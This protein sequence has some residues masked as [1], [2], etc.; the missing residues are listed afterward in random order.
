MK[1]N[2]EDIEL[3]ELFIDGELNPEETI[4]IENRLKED[5]DFARLFQLRKTLPGIWNKSNQ[6]EQVKKEVIHAFENKENKQLSFFRSRNYALAAVIL[7]FIAS[8]AIYSIFIHGHNA[9][10]SNSDNLVKKEDS[11]VIRNP[12]N[13]AAKARKET[14]STNKEK[15]FCLLEP[16]DSTTYKCTQKIL[17]QWKKNNKIATLYIFLIKTDKLVFKKEIPVGQDSCVL[18]PG[19]L[20]EGEYYWYL[21]D[22]MIKRFFGVRKKLS[23]RNQ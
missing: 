9:K 1:F 8:I 15:T 16:K 11:L 22:P 2:R 3:I 13:P 17:F 19:T 5:Q 10:N 4:R 20:N 23:E 12:E 6:Y 18:V 21:N 14:V 7:I